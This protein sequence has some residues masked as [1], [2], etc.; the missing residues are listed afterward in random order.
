M[1]A[2]GLVLIAMVLVGIFVLTRDNDD[3]EGPGNGVVREKTPTQSQSG[4]EGGPDGV[5]T[6]PAKSV[7]ILLEELPANYEVD[8]PNTFAMTVS[9]FTSSY[10][11]RSDAEGQEKAHEWRIVDGFQVWYQPK[12]LAAEALT[13]AAF[14]R[15]ETYQF[16]DVAGAQAAWGHLDSLMQR[17]DGSERVEAKPLA[18]NWGAY[19]LLEGTVGSS[20]TLAVYH[21][22][23]FRRGN[24]IVSVQTWGAD[25]YMN[26]DAARNIAA[27]IDDK[28]L[29]TRPAV[30]PTPIPTPSFPGLG[31]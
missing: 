18:S 3:E 8:V 6:L 11:F 15:V 27:A 20:D 30:E 22:F 19:R 23:N 7:S 26:I 16:V 14:V 10:W 29:G 4:T 28:L 24:I 25:P 13:G 9:T 5:F 21:R 31:N 17:I 12:G 2:A 1:L